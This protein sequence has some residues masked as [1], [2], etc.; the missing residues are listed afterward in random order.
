MQRKYPVTKK[1][2]VVDE[3]HGLRIEDPYR[4]LEDSSS[5]EVRD[6]VEQQ[7][8]LALS[9]LN[10]Y[11][12]KDTVKKR[13]RAL[14][15]Y[16]YVLPDHFS[17][18]K[19]SDGVRFFYLFREAGKN[20]AALSYQD[21]EQGERVGLFDPLTVSE[22]G[23][24]SVDWLIPSN[25]GS[26]VAF[27]IS[28]SGTENSVLHVMDVQR[29]ELLEERIPK[30]KWCSLAWLGNDGFYYSRYPL[31]G[32]VPQE[33][34]KYQHHVFYHRLGDD[35]TNDVKVFGE[36][37]EK[38]EHPGLLMNNGF[39]LLAIMSYRFTSSDIHVA[40]VDKEVPSCLDFV[41]VIESD[42]C[43]SIPYF[44]NNH[45]YV[46][47]QIRAPNGQVV[48]YD[49]SRFCRDGIIPPAEIVV[50]ESEGV[51]Y[52]SDR[53]GLAVFG[54][55]IAVIDDKNASSSLKIYDTESG[56]L[57]DDVQFGTHVTIHEIAS[58]SGLDTFYF[59]LM[60]CFEPTSYYG[61]ERHRPRIFFRPKLDLDRNDY[62][63]DLVWYT[64]KDGTK[65]SMFLLSKKGAVMTKKTPVTIT[66][67]GGFGLSSTPSYRPDFVTWLE[68]G[69]IVA[70]PHL[71]GGGE[72][73]QE[74]HRAGSRE[75]KQNTFDDF[76]AAAEW[77]IQKGI[78]SQR[79]ISSQGGSNAGLLVGAALV[80]RPDLFAAVLCIVPL[81]DMIRYTHF[82][83][84]R[85]WSKEFG[86]PSVKEEFEWLYGYSPYLHVENRRYPA[87]YLMTALNDT[88][89]DPM[90]A[91]KMAA[92]LQ[93]KSKAFEKNRPVILHTLTEEG[94]GASASTESLIDTWSNFL[95]FRAYHTGLKIREKP[96]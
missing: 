34:E 91:W 11:P 18:T 70:I 21:G 29:K 31:L 20:Q 27:G 24:I 23:L 54:R 78:G 64:S 16:D 66:G 75:N 56:T 4:W 63:S 61:Y 65:V 89:V 88:R 68:N 83:I 33:D 95:I 55:N 25:D 93:S 49:L 79:T 80:Q 36:G 45:L 3:I 51:I 85:T 2:P 72:Y 22:R 74:W 69:G 37:R 96:S 17:V 92:K 28:E 87:T 19:T 8:R 10:E 13:F 57:V 30:T 82:Q 38:T 35:Y 86:D 46:L 7:N 43:E 62:Q 6:W 15:T 41:P 12:G 32:T 60:S 58:T 52:K 48:R 59:S 14:Y 73:G 81:L 42:S 71:R 5:Q 44:A 9:V 94:H 50:K 1:V 67:Y 77:L 40:K 26:M 76:I 47:T 53:I 90:H 84:G 39:S